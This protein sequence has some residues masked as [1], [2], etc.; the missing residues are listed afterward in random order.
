MLKFKYF[1]IGIILLGHLSELIAQATI[2][3]MNSLGERITDK[4]VIISQ[5]QLVL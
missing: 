2:T 4:K 1:F 3:C 5:G